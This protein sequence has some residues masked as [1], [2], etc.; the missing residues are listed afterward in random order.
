MIR[1]ALDDGGATFQAVEQ[2]DYAKTMS[3][4]LNPVPLPVVALY[5]DPKE[6]YTD[7][8][9]AVSAAL[10]AAWYRAMAAHY[11][12]GHVEIVASSHFIHLDRPDLVLD[13]LRTLL[14][15]L[16]G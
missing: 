14:A 1:K 9:P 7:P 10:V 3:E 4:L 6:R 8:D 5:V 15:E 16:R 11:P 13:R 2:L 12:K